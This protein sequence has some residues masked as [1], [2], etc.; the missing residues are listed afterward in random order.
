MIVIRNGQQIT[1]C[2][3]CSKESRPLDKFDQ[4]YISWPSG[5]HHITQE[6][7]IQWL[8][9]KH[10]AGVPVMLH[11]CP[12]CAKKVRTCLKVNKIHNL[13]DGPLKKYLLDIIAKPDNNFKAFQIHFLKE[14]RLGQ[15]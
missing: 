11:S 9:A 12:G 15:A 5:F 10:N 14:S 3:S 7:L 6:P 8:R 13:P 4:F 1:R 2:D